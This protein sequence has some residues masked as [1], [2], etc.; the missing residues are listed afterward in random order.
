MNTVTTGA[1]LDAVADRS[2]RAAGTVSASSRAT[3][4]MSVADPMTSGDSVES[5]TAPPSTTRVVGDVS[6]AGLEC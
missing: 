5:P 4:T 2:A 3:S 1:E 6:E